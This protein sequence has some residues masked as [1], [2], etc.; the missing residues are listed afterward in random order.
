MCYKTSSCVVASSYT[1]TAVHLAHFVIFRK[2]VLS[3]QSAKQ[4]AQ[5]AEFPTRSSS[6][7][8]STVYPPSKALAK[9]L[10]AKLAGLLRLSW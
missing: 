6:S 7:L 3:G 5:E 1:L 8:S 4:D 10:S 2:L 9:Y